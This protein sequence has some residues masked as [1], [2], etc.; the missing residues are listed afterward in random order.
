[1]KAGIQAIIMKIN[2]E[3]GQHSSERYAQIKSSIDREI[4][5]ELAL[6]TAD[7]DKQRDVL[8]KHN[9]HE[10][11]RRLEYQRSRL[12]RE[13]LLYQQ[14]LTDEIFNMAVDK[15][16]NLPD[17]DFQKMFMTA[18]SGLEGSFTLH[19]GAL[20]E[21]RLGPGVIDEAMRLN[22]G[23]KVALSPE[24]IPLKSGFIIRDSRVEYNHMFEDLVEDMKSS[25]AAA[26]MKEV[27]GNS[28]DWMFS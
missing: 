26:I 14:Q 21:R 8:D 27:F 25:H 2:E 19:L 10:H 9:Q 28:G 16:K 18:V 11:A 15:L 5:E 22:K 1:M 23:L 7:S 24:T 20:S 17:A 13:L 3:A 12:N 4:D 6:F